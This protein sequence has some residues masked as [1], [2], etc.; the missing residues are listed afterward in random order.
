[1]NLIEKRHF[2]V[3]VRLNRGFGHFFSLFA[4][5]ELFCFLFPA[6]KERGEKNVGREKKEAERLVKALSRRRK[7]LREMGQKKKVTEYNQR[8][9]GKKAVTQHHLNRSTNRALIEP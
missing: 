4:R 2:V 3:V 6:A 9:G 1:M 8:R 5:L 7:E